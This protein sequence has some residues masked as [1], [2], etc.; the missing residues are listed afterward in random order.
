MVVV[1]TYSGCCRATEAKK[2][3]KEVNV[4]FEILPELHLRLSYHT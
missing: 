3:G 4:K 1:F 2:N